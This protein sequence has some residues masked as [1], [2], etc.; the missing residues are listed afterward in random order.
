MT[1][2]SICYRAREVISELWGRP[3]GNGSQSDGKGFIFVANA[4]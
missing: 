3:F 1:V 4:A 2:S